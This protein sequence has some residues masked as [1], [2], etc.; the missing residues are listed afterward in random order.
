VCDLFLFLQVREEPLG[1]DARGRQYYF[2][3]A[4][5]H[6]LWVHAPPSCRDAP[7]WQWAFYDTAAQVSAHAHSSPTKN[8]STR[9]SHPI[10]GFVFG[11]PFFGKSFI[12]YNS[13]HK[14]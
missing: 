7:Q 13:H 9:A 2:F 6:R 1:V 14:S 4:D 5:P 10:V 3:F 12:T 11:A 8:N